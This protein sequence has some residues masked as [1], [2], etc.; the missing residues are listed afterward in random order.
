MT[1]IAN[2]F[3]ITEETKSKNSIPF[4]VTKDHPFNTCTIT[5]IAFETFDKKDGTPTS[6][7]MIYLTSE[8]K[9]RTHKEIEWLLDDKDAK[10]GDKLSAFQSRMK[11]IYEEFAPF[12]KDGIGIKSAN[13]EE[14]FK[15]VETAF[16]TNGMNGTPIYTDKLVYL[17]LVYYNG[18]LKFP[19]A[20][21]FIE[22]VKILDGNKRKETTLVIN[23]KYD[24][25]DNDATNKNTP[26]L[27]PENSNDFVEDFPP[28]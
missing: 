13:V 18:N 14:F 24:K 28:L 15:A 11:H 4:K 10:F 9:E 7:L 17:K 26:S 21:N 22:K 20:P 12:P 16:N 5:K 1:E 6:A 23:P 27:L 3:G 8:N 2:K 19:Y 25:V